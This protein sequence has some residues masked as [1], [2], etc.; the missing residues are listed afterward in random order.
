MF[1]RLKRA[2]SFILRAKPPP[3][4]LDLSEA[5]HLRRTTPIN[6]KVLAVVRDQTL[7]QNSNSKIEKPTKATNKDI[8][9]SEK[10]KIHPKEEVNYQFKNKEDERHNTDRK[11]INALAEFKQETTGKKVSRSKSARESR[12]QFMK[13]YPNTFH[14][15]DV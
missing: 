14:V 15:E 11:Q 5:S 13:R 3:V 9:A 6:S 4:E 1:D 10:S 2:K 7:R 12:S 8:E